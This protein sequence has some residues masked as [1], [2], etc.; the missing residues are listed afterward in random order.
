M[1]GYVQYIYVTHITPAGVLASAFLDLD[2]SQDEYSHLIG[3]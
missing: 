3:Y 1:H 2:Y